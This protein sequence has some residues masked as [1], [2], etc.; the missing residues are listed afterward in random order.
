M[1]IYATDRKAKDLYFNGWRIKEAWVEA[2]KVYS[3]RRVPKAWEPREYAVGEQ[4]IF[5]G[6]VWEAISPV[7]GSDKYYQPSSSSYS[8]KFWKFV[9]AA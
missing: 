5:N 3:R 9:G 2:K 8:K 7:T 6:S 1:P 4:V